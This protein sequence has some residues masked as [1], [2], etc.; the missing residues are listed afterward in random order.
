MQEN[1]EISVNCNPLRW[2]PLKSE[3]AN[4][5]CVSLV[6]REAVPWDSTCESG[7]H[8]VS[9]VQPQARQVVQLKVY[10]RK[11]PTAGNQWS[12]RGKG[13]SRAGQ[14]G[15]CALSTNTTSLPWVGSPSLCLVEM[16][17]SV[18]ARETRESGRAL[19]LPLLSYFLMLRVLSLPGWL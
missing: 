4:V 13:W 5:S 11:N 8:C 2:W 17:M 16:L 9:P 10:S 1:G 3:S 19:L 15:R 6:I 7:P 12:S 18:R 14:C